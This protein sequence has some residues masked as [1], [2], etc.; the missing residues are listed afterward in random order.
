MSLNSF[1]VLLITLHHHKMIL[2]IISMRLFLETKTMNFQIK[3]VKEK[4]K[5]SLI[6]RYLIFLKKALKIKNLNKCKN[7]KNSKKITHKSKRNMFLDNRLI[8]KN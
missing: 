1:L 5:I 2:I 7:Y 3:I 6:K 8:M 4:V